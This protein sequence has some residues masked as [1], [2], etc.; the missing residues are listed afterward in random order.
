MKNQA[1]HNSYFADLKKNSMEDDEITT[2]L[3]ILLPVC[4]ELE[5]D[6]FLN[7]L[8]N[9]IGRK[10]LDDYY[11]DHALKLGMSSDKFFLK[12]EDISGSWN[13]MKSKD[14]QIRQSRLLGYWAINNFPS[15]GKKLFGN[16][17]QIPKR[18]NLQVI[19]HS[20]EISADEID[21]LVFQKMKIRVMQLNVSSSTLVKISHFVN[22]PTNIGKKNESKISIK[23]KSFDPDDEWTERCWKALKLGSFSLDGN[24]EVSF[25]KLI[26][27]QL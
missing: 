15:L 25:P 23:I 9:V 22:V 5:T 14:N 21:E 3:F 11:I 2:P 13:D 12:E 20:K 19:G 6:V 27:D 1:H 26:L 4:T 17:W 10:K 7:I 18:Q 16:S 8:K 24:Y